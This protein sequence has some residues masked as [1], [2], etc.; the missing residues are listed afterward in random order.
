M[1]DK[2]KLIID[3]DSTFI[4]LETIEILASFA[5]NE[6]NHR[7]EIINQIKDITNRAMIGEIPFSDALDQRIKLIQPKPEHIDKTIF[8]LKNK[9]TN[10]FNENKKFFKQHY[11]NCYIISGGFKEI[12][13]PIVRDFNILEKQIF[14]NTFLYKNKKIGIDKDNALSKNNGKNLIAKNIDGF[15]IIIG[16]GY[17]DYEVKKYGNAQKFIQFTENI[18]R[19]SLNKKADLICDDFK[20]IIDYINNDI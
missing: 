14:A 20:I 15:N 1:D 6:K 19:K 11:K 13:I 17:T 18:N 8:F 3:F 10:S 9:I 12:I 5:L 2:I 7:D 16:D 4:K